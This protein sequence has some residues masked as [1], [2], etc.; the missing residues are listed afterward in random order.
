MGFGYLFPGHVLLDPYY[1]DSFPSK[2]DKTLN[3]FREYNLCN[4]ILP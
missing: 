2:N 3:I 1:L 4:T